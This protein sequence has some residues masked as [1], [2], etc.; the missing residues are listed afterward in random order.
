MSHRAGS[1]LFH[2]LGPQKIKLHCYVLVILY[3]VAYV[4][5]M[6]PV[7]VSRLK[8]TFFQLVV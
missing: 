8:K 4:T 7:L 6:S 3:I 2:A 5:L 1:K